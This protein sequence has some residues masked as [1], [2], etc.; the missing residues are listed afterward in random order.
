MSLPGVHLHSEIPSR[1]FVASIQQFANL[2]YELKA[3]V[4]TIIVT[5]EAAFTAVSASV[6]A[7]VTSANLAI[8]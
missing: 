8:A 7:R 1:L 3:K 5:V 2:S 6:G 4:S